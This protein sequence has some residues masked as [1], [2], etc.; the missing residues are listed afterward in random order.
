MKNHYLD[1]GEKKSVLLREVVCILDADTA[2]VS[3][4]TRAFLKKNTEKGNLVSPSPAIRM[5]NAIVITNAFGRDK[6]FFS[7]YT[8]K[9]LQKNANLWSAASRPGK[10]SL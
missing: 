4:T 3:K 1:V 10:E 6:V 7:P 9:R 2:T 5:V 8:V